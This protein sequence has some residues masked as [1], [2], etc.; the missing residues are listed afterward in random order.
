MANK[1]PIRW[2]IQEGAEKYTGVAMFYRDHEEM[3]RNS[4]SQPYRSSQRILPDGYS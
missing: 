1:K 4:F 2:A 3:L